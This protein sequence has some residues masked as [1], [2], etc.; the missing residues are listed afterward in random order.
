[1]WAEPLVRTAG[2]EWWRNAT[3]WRPRYVGVKTKT[4][5]QTP[6]LEAQGWLQ[7]FRRHAGLPTALRTT[8]NAARKPDSEGAPTATGPTVE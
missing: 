5:V 8:A 4:I 1:M 3:A 2:I 7:R 6:S